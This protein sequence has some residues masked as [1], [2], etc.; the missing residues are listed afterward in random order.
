MIGVWHPLIAL[1]VQ[2]VLWYLTGNSWYGVCT[3]FFF[4]GR[5]LA[6]AE[7]RWIEQF[8]SGLRRNMPWHAVL[9][10]KVWS[11]HSLTDWLLPIIFTV[12]VAVLV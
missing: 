1:V 6:Q 9:D 10:P 12:V 3:S 8:G 4:L 7:Y 2:G 5:E 11:V